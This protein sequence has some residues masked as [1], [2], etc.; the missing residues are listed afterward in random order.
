MF[1]LYKKE[2]TI[3]ILENCGQGQIRDNPAD[4]VGCCKCLTANSTYY[5]PAYGEQISWFY[6]TACQ[7]AGDILD[8]LVTYRQ[9]PEKDR[10]AYLCK[11]FPWW[12]GHYQNVKS[13]IERRKTRLAAEAYWEELGTR[14]WLDPTLAGRTATCDFLQLSARQWDEAF[15]RQLYANE[16]ISRAHLT[17]LHGGVI[18]ERLKAFATLKSRPLIMRL[19]NRPGEF[20]GFLFLKTGDE[21]Q[22]WYRGLRKNAPKGFGML[23]ALYTPNNQP[24]HKYLF[25]DPATALA[26]AAKYKLEMGI[27]SPIAFLPMRAVGYANT[28]MQHVSRHFPALT[29]WGDDTITAKNIAIKYNVTY[30][31]HVP[32]QVFGRNSDIANKANI[33]LNNIFKTRR[34]QPLTPQKELR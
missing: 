19:S 32:E 15:N 5:F 4:I 21:V 13:Y 10:G 30:S 20:T 33:L 23:E 25:L 7:F 3:N 26:T 9:V 16:R 34:P 2:L 12:R 14:F 1:Q 8:Y 29:V 27:D 18:R 31:D 17:E 22:W 6:C 28:T 11:L 24:H